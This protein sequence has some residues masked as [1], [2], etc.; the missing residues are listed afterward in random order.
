[1]SGAASI[2]RPGIPE[3]M[4]EHAVPAADIV[5]PNQFELDFCP[6]RTSATRRDALA[7]IDALHALGPRRSW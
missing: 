5:T 1:M 2:V 3:F 7:A 4:R 6:G